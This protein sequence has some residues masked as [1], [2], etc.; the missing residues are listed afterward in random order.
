[1]AVG[2]VKF[3]NTQKGFGFITP[4]DGSR[5]VFVHI[6]AV[7]R[8]GMSTLREG[9]RVSYDVVTERGKQAEKADRESNT[10]HSGLVA[11]KPALLTADLCRAKA[12]EC[13]YLAEQAAS[14]P[15][16]IMLGHIVE[17]WY[18]I[19]DSLPANDA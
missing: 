5:D 4:A 1:M 2:T 16:R 18:R 8:S 19:A 9:Q 10:L 17:T 12:V 11:E 6:S 15:H 7:E 3:F 14:Q 13:L